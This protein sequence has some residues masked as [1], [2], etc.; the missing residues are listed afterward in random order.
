MSNESNPSRKGA[1]AGAPAPGAPCPPSRPSPHRER[2]ASSRRAPRPPA[3]AAAFALALGG[4]AC[5][6][7]DAGVE[8]PD[9]LP[10][11]DRHVVTPENGPDPS[12]TLG[13][14]KVSPEAC[15]GI[16]TH[17]VTQKLSPEDLSRFLEAQ[18]AGSIAPKLARSNLYWFDFPASDESFVRLRLAVLDSSRHATQDLHDALLQHGPG[19]WGVRRSNLAVLAPKASLREAMAFAIKYKLVC[20][21]VF[22]YAGNDDA[23]VVPGPY[24][25]L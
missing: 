24:A 13:E 10:E 16:D 6:G 5:S 1:P 11:I 22:T 19:W 21:G 17:T 4:A 7:I 18:G 3:L 25:E 14:F 20:W 8:Y 12:I 15:K 23:Y 9:D 2:P